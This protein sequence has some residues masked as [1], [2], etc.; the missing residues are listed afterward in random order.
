MHPILARKGWLGQYLA[1]CT[2][3]GV[4]LLLLFLKRAGFTFFEAAALAVPMQILYAF[5]ALSEWYVC[6][7]VRLSAATAVRVLATHAVKGVVDRTRPLCP[8]PQV[9]RYKGSGSTSEAANFT[10]ALP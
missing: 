7:S 4:G 2:P 10:C 8:Y 3:I 9:A 5:L 1:A 6:Q